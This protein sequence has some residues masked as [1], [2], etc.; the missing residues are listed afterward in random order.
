VKTG[1]LSAPRFSWANAAS[2]RFLDIFDLAFPMADFVAAFVRAAAFF[3]V[4]FA[5]AFFAAGLLA[6]AFFAAGFFAAGFLAAVFFAAV[7]FAAGFFAV[8]LAVDFFAVDFAAA[9]FAGAFFFAVDFDFVVA[10]FFVAMGRSLRRVI[11][12]VDRERYD[13]AR[14]NHKIK[15]AGGA[16][17]DVRG[18]IRGGFGAPAR[19]PRSR[20]GGGS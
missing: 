13:A 7:F 4:F 6:A 15:D 17:V 5:A 18:V 14:E 12:T 11:A 2:Q 9:F 3:T 20:C 10:A 8:A 1:R 16:V 19:P